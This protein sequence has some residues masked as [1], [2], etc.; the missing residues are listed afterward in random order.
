MEDY[1]GKTCPFCKAEIKQGDAVKVCPSCN[2]PHHEICWEENNG[3]FFGCPKQS[4]K[5]DVSPTDVCV[6]CGSPLSDDHGFCPKC[7]TPRGG[8]KKRICEKC[9]VE[10]LDDQDFCP[11]CGTRYSEGN[12][13]ADSTIVSSDDRSRKKAL[14]PI[15]AG[16]AVLIIGL[17]LFFVLR[18]TPVAEVCFS[19][20]AVTIT[21]GKTVTLVCTVSPDDAKDKTLVWTSSNEGIA[22]VS[23][24]GTVTAVSEGICTITASSANGKNDECKVTVEKAGPDF[25]FLYSVFCSSTY[26]TL[27]SD[28]SFLSIDTNPYDIDDYTVDGS[29]AAIIA[30][31]EAL[32][33]PD[34]ILDDM[35]STTSLMGKQ[36]ESFPDLGVTVSWTYHPDNGLEV[37]YKATK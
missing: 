27:G 17:I 1:I 30:V 37:M 18:G 9:G 12:D 20:D 11:K 13:A 21:E 25:E 7:G 2:I 16:I 28:G 35:G 31:N 29:I 15:I 32:G 5:E 3:C 23:D 34:Y 6:N 4:D 36:S 26:A 33:L 10:L 24:T 8:K 19:K 14:I 22:T